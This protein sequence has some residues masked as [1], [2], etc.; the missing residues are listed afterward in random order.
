M[1]FTILGASGFVG[2]HLVRWLEARSLPYWAP[3]R[4]EGIFDRSLGHVIYCIGLT[5][6]F[7][8]R[9]YD[10]ARAHVCYL[11]DI[12]E[13]AEFASFLYLSTTRLYRGMQTSHEDTGLQVNPLLPDDL[14]NISKIMG[15]SVC[16]ACN[17]TNV[18]VAR[19]ANVYGTDFSS[20]NF[21]FSVIRSAVDNGH[22]VLRTSM[23]SEK[24]YVSINDVVRL[25]PEIARS[26]RYRIYNV[27]SGVNTTNGALTDAI[28]RETG[29]TIEVADKAETITF[30]PISTARIREEF[31]VSPA[32]VLD[33]LGDLIAQY[34]REATD[35]DQDRYGKQPGY[36]RG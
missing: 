20:T 11:L 25:L 5:A 4:D 8:Q 2:S 16:F 12:L 34:R 7:R 28:Q 6:D 26:G 9:P 24:D 19:L 33:S 3:K 30:P 18:R 32:S 23:T 17:R 15:E 27:A 29:C 31:G 1:R 21:L 10:T 14:Y 36:R 13:K 35:S 22:V